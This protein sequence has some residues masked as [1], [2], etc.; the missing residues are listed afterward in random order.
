MIRTRVSQN[1]RVALAARSLRLVWLLLLVATASG[2]P[3]GLARQEALEVLKEA[4]RG[5]P[6]GGFEF[7]AHNRRFR[8][9]E[10]WS[11][12]LERYFRAG[13]LKVYRQATGATKIPGHV[14]QDIGEYAGQG[15]LSVV[16]RRQ[17]RRDRDI[18]LRFRF[19]FFA[20]VVQVRNRMCVIGGEGKPIGSMLNTKQFNAREFID[21]RHGAWEENGKQ[22]AERRATRNHRSR[23]DAVFSDNT[24]WMRP[25]RELLQETLE[26]MVGQPDS[27]AFRKEGGKVVATYFVTWPRFERPAITGYHSA[28]SGKYEWVF[29]KESPERYR[30]YDGHGEL[31]EE[32]RLANIVTDEHG[33]IPLDVERRTWF[34][35]ASR[36]MRSEYVAQGKRAQ[37]RLR[38][39]TL[40]QLL[41]KGTRVTDNRFNPPVVYSVNHAPMQDADVAELSAHAADQRPL[42]RTRW[43]GGM[44]GEPV[45]REVEFPPNESGA[46]SV[47]VDRILLGIAA[48]L[49]LASVFLFW[50][51]GRSR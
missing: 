13:A 4:L 38:P 1:D 21:R 18:P 51:L 30:V 47:W 22:F 45:D 8:P 44:D 26:D 9:P 7:E 39:T 42:L 29:T 43:E 28:L 10:G 34:P 2:H 6:R 23:H 5:Y 20:D 33:S 14:R 32:V 19:D 46:A 12:G 50:H 16:A 31:L 15:A 41:D 27:W 24:Q 11:K 3:D 48:T 37:P 40:A 49:G 35:G 17:P 25:G 36:A